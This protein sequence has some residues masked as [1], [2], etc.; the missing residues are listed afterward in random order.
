MYQPACGRRPAGAYWWCLGQALEEV[1]PVASPLVGE[2]GSALFSE[3]HRQTRLRIAHPWPILNPPRVSTRG[4]GPGCLPDGRGTGFCALR[5]KFD[6]FPQDRVN[7]LPPGWA[8][9]DR[10]RDPI[11]DPQ[12]RLFGAEAM[13]PDQRRPGTPNASDREVVLAVI[14]STFQHQM[15]N[16]VALQPS[17]D[18]R[19]ANFAGAELG[20]AVVAVTDHHEDGDGILGEPGQN[21]STSACR[22]VV[23]V[24]ASTCK[25]E[26]FNVGSERC[27]M[28]RLDQHTAHQ[29]TLAATGLIHERVGRA[30]SPAH[31]LRTLLRGYDNYSTRIPLIALAIT[32]CWISLVPSKMVWIF[33]SRCQRS[34]GYSRV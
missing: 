13:L 18:L 20:D 12:Q 21:E 3:P 34:T 29:V 23:K 17:D 32:S 30:E 28:L 14:M 4:S 24:H 11:C 26:T 7:Q 5:A 33:A 1:D 25:D 16:S 9:A 27:E 8:C 2:P 19:E 31:Y 22:L 10:P 15:R 6:N